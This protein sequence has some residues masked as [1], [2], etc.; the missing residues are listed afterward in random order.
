VAPPPKPPRKVKEKKPI[1]RPRK[2]RSAE[3]EAEFNLRLEEK[4]LGIKR[5]QGRPRKYDGYLVREM[6]LKK[7]RAEFAEV[8]R[9]HA[10]SE[11]D[12]ATRAGEE[13][14]INGEINGN[15]EA[16]PSR[17]RLHDDGLAGPANPGVGAGPGG[18]DE[19]DEMEMDH[20]H[21]LQHHH[22]HDSQH[23]LEGELERTID[24]HYDWEHDPQSLLEV[25]GRGI[26]A[27][28]AEEDEANRL[29]G[30]DVEGLGGVDGLDGLDGLEG[31]GGA[32]GL[33]GVGQQD[34]GEPSGQPLGMGRGDEAIRVVFGLEHEAVEH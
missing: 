30:M 21:Q 14:G 10:E 9:R 7:N 11:R 2:I 5:K 12:G 31:L 26:A 15:A 28:A 29:D 3:E 6:R 22:H 17:I 8:I 32:D 27:V 24:E 23:P 20:Q 4:R 34:G 33:D 1:G 16:G 13:G 18:M 19:M 25:V